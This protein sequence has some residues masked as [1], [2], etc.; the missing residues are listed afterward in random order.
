M[1][2]SPGTERALMRLAE[3]APKLTHEIERL[4]DNLE[5]LERRRR[6]D[7]PPKKGSAEHIK[8][9]ITVSEK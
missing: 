2:M 5:K 8:T 7:S 6:E 3:I 9:E 1:G 4:N